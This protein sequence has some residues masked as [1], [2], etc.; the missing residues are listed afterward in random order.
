MTS[1]ARILG[2]KSIGLRCPD[3]E[4]SCCDDSQHP[5]K[6]TLIQMPN[7]TGKT[8]TLTLLRAALSGAAATGSWSP[9]TVR[10]FRKRSPESESGTF[11]VRLLLNQR[12]VTIKLIFDFNV[13]TVA[14]KTT[15]S[16]G[17]V[18]RFEPPA[19]FTQ[20]LN[21]SFVNFFVFDGELAHNLL[22]RRHTDAELVVE[23]LFQIS[24]LKSIKEEVGAYW[25]RRTEGLTAT[26]ERGRARRRNQLQRL[27]ER[28]EA[29]IQERDALEKSRSRLQDQVDE[30]YKEYEHEIQK[31]EA[32]SADLQNLQSQAEKLKND[33]REQALKILEIMRDPHALSGVFADRLSELKTGLDRA[34]LPES[35]AREFFEELAEESACICGRPIDDEISSTIRSRASGYLAS[36]DVGF[37]NAMKEDIQDALR[38]DK[39]DRES[40]LKEQLEALIQLTGNLRETSQR[41][42]HLRLQAES[43]DPRAKKARDEYESLSQKLDEVSRDLEK[44]ADSDDSLDWEKTYGVEVI[45]ARIER[46]E[47]RLAEINNT[48]DLKRKRDVLQGILGDAYEKARSGINRKL[49]DEANERI[50]RLLPNNAIRIEKIDGC[51]ALEGQEGGSA[52]ETLSVAYAFLATLF[53]RSEHSLPFIVDSPAGPIDNDVRPKIGE[54]VPKLSSQFIAFIISSERPYF[55]GPLIGA[56]A[57]PVNFMTVFRKSDSRAANYQQG[58]YEY[59]EE[60]DGVIVSGERFF[61]EFQVD[62]E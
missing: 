17:Q 16:H 60:G 53:N 27:R 19:D 41:A 18:N 28:Y 9:E 48:L 59:R 13:G 1:E 10:E 55:V 37:L 44:F 2:W 40:Q 33:A 29:L 39:D 35:A 49:C 58:G 52:G 54:L 50:Y 20:F 7:G 5:H 24:T 30:Q 56:A 32:H 31:Q 21:P 36:D 25:N 22:D 15:R 42:E 26:A 6:V 51:L 14:Y 11:E 23:S 62:L 61:D 45:K 38:A 4:V 46:E 57:E 47:E 12:P 3:H 34:K 8:T 43:S